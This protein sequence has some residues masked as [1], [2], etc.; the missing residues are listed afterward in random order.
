MNVP[1]CKLRCYV[2]SPS[3]KVLNSRL[4]TKLS[5]QLISYCFFVL[6]LKFDNLSNKCQLRQSKACWN[7]E[8]YKVCKF[9][10]FSYEFISIIS[11]GSEFQFGPPPLPFLKIYLSISTFLFPGNIV[12]SCF[13]LDISHVKC[14]FNSVQ[15]FQKE[16]KSTEIGI[17][18]EAMSGIARR[19]IWVLST[20]RKQRET[21]LLTRNGGK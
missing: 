2:P 10:Y 8:C 7:L 14:V 4:S 12:I 20:L 6:W 1:F 5:I 3:T 18:R 17:D 15:L 13:V 9:F 21:S 11:W 19:V 16:I